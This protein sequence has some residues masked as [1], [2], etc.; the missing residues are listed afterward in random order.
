MLVAFL[1]TR[2]FRGTRTATAAFNFTVVVIFRL[3]SV[4]RSGDVIVT[5]LFYRLSRDVDAVFLVFF[6]HTTRFFCNATRFFFQFTTCLFFGFALKFLRFGFTT[7]FFSLGSPGHFVRL[8]I[9]HFARFRSFAF[10]RIS[11]FAFRFFFGFTF[12]FLLCVTFGFIL[13]FTLSS[14]LRFTTGLLFRFALRLFFR[15]ETFSLLRIAFYKGAFFADFDLH[16]FTF[17]AGARDIQCAARFAL[18][19][20]FVRR[21]TVFTVQVR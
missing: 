18:Q 10:R 16:R 5:A 1:R 20:Q 19:R 11:G 3:A 12:R 6:R 14:F 9:A 8:L 2:R 21:R 17:P 13:G 4:L 15:G 7:G